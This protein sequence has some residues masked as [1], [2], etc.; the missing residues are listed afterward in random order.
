MDEATLPEGEP[1]M[2][3]IEGCGMDDI[4]M[5]IGLFVKSWHQTPIELPKTWVE[6]LNI[7]SSKFS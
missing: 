7:K 1:E 2:W 4:R 6:S 5:H 3:M